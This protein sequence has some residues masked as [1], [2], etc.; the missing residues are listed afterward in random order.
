VQVVGT[1]LIFA[2][3]VTPAATAQRL[4]SRPWLAV[5]LS[6]FLAVLF[7]WLGLAVAYFAP[8]SVVG[9]YVTTFAFAAYAA[10]RLWA[11]VRPSRTM[12]LF[13]RRLPA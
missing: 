1:L 10:T 2:L 7:T 8:Y 11:A 4:T 12:T 9:F 13:P 6:V 5:T 3:L